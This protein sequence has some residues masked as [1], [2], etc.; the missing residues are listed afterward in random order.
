MGEAASRVCGVAL[1]VLLATGPAALGDATDL[2]RLARCV[3]VSLTGMC[4]SA[5]RNKPLAVQGATDVLR[6]L[7]RLV[8]HEAPREALL[9]DAG[10]AHLL[11]RGVLTLHGCLPPLANSARLMA[12]AASSA[13]DK[14][15]ALAKKKKGGHGHALEEAR[16]ILAAEVVMGPQ[17]MGVYETERA[18]RAALAALSRHD[19]FLAAVKRLR[20]CGALCCHGAAVLTMR[21][22]PG[23]AAS[24]ANVTADKLLDAA[25]DAFM[26]AANAADAEEEPQ[27]GAAE[28]DALIS[29]DEPD[30]A[31]EDAVGGEY[32]VP[33][34]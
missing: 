8:D 31:D 20:G 15:N 5:L 4:K 12:E 7:A 6:L 9:G 27:G 30:G 22:R 26:L 13:S 17:A 3:A 29:D 34:V 10:V 23:E 2:R 25:C 1:A 14:A 19:R 24:E 18:C 33:G 11:A 21:I 28:V 16:K 32:P